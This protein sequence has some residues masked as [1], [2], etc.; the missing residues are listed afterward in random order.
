MPVSQETRPM[1][2]LPD[3]PPRIPHKLRFWIFMLVGVD[4]AL[5]GLLLV[6]WATPIKANLPNP[7]Q[8]STHSPVAPAAIVTVALPTP[9]QT[10]SA[11]MT[12]SQAAPVHRVTPTAHRSSTAPVA[13][14][15]AN[16]PTRSSQPSVYPTMTVTPPKP[17]TPASTPSGTIPP[18]GSRT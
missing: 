11:I 6:I 13:V 5:L 14:P 4:L 2:R 18:S 3:S 9:V 10:H 7:Q 16:A 8:T 15:T 17:S 1:R 12:P